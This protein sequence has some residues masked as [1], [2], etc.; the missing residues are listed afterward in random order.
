MRTIQQR[1]GE[2]DFGRLS[3]ANRQST[4]TKE[5]VDTTIRMLETNLDPTSIDDLLTTLHSLSD[6]PG[7][8]ERLN[9]VIDAFNN[10]GVQQGPV[11]TY[12]SFFNTLLSSTDLD[13]L[14]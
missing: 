10:L 2:E 11:L 13:D 8:H 1:I 9:L 12:T 14:S 7:D 5:Q 3:A 4:I 6:A